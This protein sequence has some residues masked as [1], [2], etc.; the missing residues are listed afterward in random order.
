MDMDMLECH[1]NKL[2]VIFKPLEYDL[3]IC[4]RKFINTNIISIKIIKFLWTCQCNNYIHKV[5]RFI[6]MQQC[7]IL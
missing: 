2:N 1:Q 6:R 3:R 5:K 4:F 7:S